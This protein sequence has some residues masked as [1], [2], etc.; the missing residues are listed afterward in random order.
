MRR[1]HLGGEA[2][3]ASS[4]FATASLLDSISTMS[5]TATSLTK[6]GVVTDTDDGIDARLLSQ[7][8]ATAGPANKAQARTIAILLVAELPWHPSGALTICDGSMRRVIAMFRS[9]GTCQHLAAADYATGRD[10]WR[11]CAALPPEWTGATERRSLCGSLPREFAAAAEHRRRPRP[12]ALVGQCS[13]SRSVAADP[14][15]KSMKRKALA[16]VE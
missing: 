4:G 7:D 11:S 15:V 9:C 1:D 6:S 2:L 3:V 16:T 13:L 8:W 10:P 14:D 5:L 12:P